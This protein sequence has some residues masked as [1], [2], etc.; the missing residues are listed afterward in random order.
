[1]SAP[2]STS[3]EELT[4]LRVCERAINCMGIHIDL[5]DVDTSTGAHV[6]RE[7]ELCIE[8]SLS[9]KNPFQAQRQPKLLLRLLHHL[10]FP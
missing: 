6:I 7:G 2:E 3:V 9:F 1:M 10:Q 4:T 5:F 8:A